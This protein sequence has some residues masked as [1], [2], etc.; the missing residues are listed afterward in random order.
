MEEDSKK[1]LWWGIPVVVAVGLA[2]ALYYGRK[3]KEE[4]VAVEQVREEPVATVTDGPANHPIES[5]TSNAAPLPALA[6]SD[7]AMKDSLAGVFGRSL[8]QFLVPRDLVRHMVAT[9]D[10]LP[11]KKVAMQT[12]PL[13][14]TTGKPVVTSEGETITWSNE[15]LARYAPLMGVVRNTDT[16]QVA[17]VYKRYYP[18]FQQ[19]YTELGYPDGYFNNRL[20]EVIDHLLQAPDVQGPV[21]LTQPGVFYQFADPTLE[22]RS[23]GQKLLIRMGSDNAAAIKLKLRELRREI[24]KQGAA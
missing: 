18:L 11:R 4:P 12:W 15:N 13:L 5:D 6:Q 24:A 19:A 14:P 3:H 17:A 20:V 1:W 16:K 2:A 10:N 9:I 22:E 7:A 21:E 23:A 8:E